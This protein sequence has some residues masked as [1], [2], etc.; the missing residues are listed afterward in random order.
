MQTDLR[1]TATAATC[2]LLALSLSGCVT[3][4]EAREVEEDPAVEVA[5][6]S[7]EVEEASP[8]P[9]SPEVDEDDESLDGD[10]DAGED[11]AD[12]EADAEGDETEVERQDP[13]DEAEDEAEG[14]VEEADEVTEDEADGPRGT[15]E[16]PFSLGESFAHDDWEV[17]INEVTPEADDQVLA[18][19]QF[20][21]PAPDGTS[22]MLIHTTVTYHGADSEM[23]M[24]GVD[25]AFVSGSGETYSSFDTL[26]IPPDE[27]DTWQ[28]LYTGGSAEGNI[29]IAVPDEGD[30]LI[31]ARLGFISTDDG[32]FAVN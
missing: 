25:F 20:N 6:E 8:S 11:V 32:F 28:E 24:M 7:P 26:S 14:D 13:D 23:I 3:L 19:N 9:E 31:R 30:G 27:L 5:G 10:E 18:E 1:R 22:Y 29:A 16:D 17:V 21:D 2:T 15:R 12:D 4:G